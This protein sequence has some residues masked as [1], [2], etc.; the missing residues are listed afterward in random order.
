[1]RAIHA[2]R[3]HLDTQHCLSREELIATGYLITDMPRY[4]PPEAP[5]EEPQLAPL[6]V[7]WER[8][9]TAV[10]GVWQELRHLWEQVQQTPRS[11]PPEA[12]RLEPREAPREKAQ[13]EPRVTPQAAPRQRGV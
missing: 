8:L 4:T 2:G 5:Q 9:T 7:L 1:Q 12:P 10:E 11:T 6:L 3:L 13:G